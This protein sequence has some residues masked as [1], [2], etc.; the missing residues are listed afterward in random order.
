MNETT[1]NMTA[2]EYL[3]RAYRIDYRISSKIEQVE[4]LRGLAEKAT[5]T[6][7]DMPFNGT[8]NGHRME[9][10]ITKAMDLESEIYAD[11]CRLI[12]TKRDIATVIQ[13]VENPELQTI[14]EL[15]YLCSKTWEEISVTQRLDIRWIHRLHNKALAEV[16]RIRH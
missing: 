6:L 3:S 2:K 16:D 13:S 1:P 15:R 7:P 5:A 14:L 11:L 10:F 12:D 4:S 9:D 8:C